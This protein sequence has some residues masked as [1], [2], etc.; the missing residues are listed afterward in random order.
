MT[1]RNTNKLI[2]AGC[3]LFA[4]W[5][6]VHIDVVD[7]MNEW[8]N[9]AFYETAAKAED[10]LRDAEYAELA[11]ESKFDLELHRVGGL[12]WAG[13]NQKEA[14][15]KDQLFQKRIAAGRRP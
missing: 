11:R 4:G 7:M 12:S 5:L 6:L 10:R 2:I 3:C 14:K 15:R 8:T 13:I 9:G 1:D